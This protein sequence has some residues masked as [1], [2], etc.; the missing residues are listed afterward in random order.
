M[1]SERDLLSEDVHRLGD[2]LGETLVEQEGRALYDLVEE[3]RALAKAHRAG[4]EAKGELLLRRIEGLP[5]DESRGVLK[6]F[7]SYFKLVNLAEERE[8]QSP[9]IGRARRQALDRTHQVE[10]ESPDPTARERHRRRIGFDAVDRG[11]Q[12]IERRPRQGLGHT[13][14]LPLE[15]VREKAQ[16]LARRRSEKTVAGDAL[17][18]GDALEQETDRRERRQALVRRERRQR[19]REQLA[20]VESDAPVLI[21]SGEIDPVTPPSWGEQV[22]QHLP[23]SRHIVSP[24]TGHGVMSVGCGMRLIGEFLEAGSAADLDASCLDVQARPAFFLNFTGPY[25]LPEKDAAQ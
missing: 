1:A 16:D 24:G 21:L 12:G 23:N 2:L 17:A 11:A 15:P 6:A 25:P 3:V 8:R 20:A 18:P 10:A 7:S 9:R 14:A 22:A 4:D 5:L 19:F 13:V